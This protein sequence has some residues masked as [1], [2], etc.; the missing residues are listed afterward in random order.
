M[1]RGEEKKHVTR[2]MTDPSPVRFKVDTDDFSLSSLYWVRFEPFMR[3]KRES[4]LAL[5]ASEW[6]DNDFMQHFISFRNAM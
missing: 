5:G 4:L 1:S 2:D 3:K 6:K